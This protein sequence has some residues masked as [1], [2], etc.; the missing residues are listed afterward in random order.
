MASMPSTTITNSRLSYSMN[1]N[2]YCGQNIY[3]ND[4]FKLH[5]R[6]NNSRHDGCDG[7]RQTDQV[8]IGQTHRHANVFLQRLN[9]AAASAF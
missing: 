7:A 9:S 6:N 3:H 4:N 8:N 2:S 1:V 5:S